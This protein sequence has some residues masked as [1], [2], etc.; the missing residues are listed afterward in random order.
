MAEFIW[1]GLTWSGNRVHAR[2]TPSGSKTP[3]GLCGREAFWTARGSDLNFPHCKHC[4]R[5]LA[6][7][8]T[9]ERRESE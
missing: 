6:R 8:K 4:E 1:D 5:E 3:L 7:R 2:R 9:A